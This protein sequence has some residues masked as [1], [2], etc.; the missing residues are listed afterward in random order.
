ME[1]EDEEEDEEE[2]EEEEE[3]KDVLKCI[4]TNI[5]NAYNLWKFIYFNTCKMNTQFDDIIRLVKC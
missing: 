1:E 5:F 2:E 3:E 4:I